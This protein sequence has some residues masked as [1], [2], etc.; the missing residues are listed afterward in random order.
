MLNRIMIVEDEYV[1][2]LDLKNLLEDL[3]HQV[4]AMVARGEDVVAQA[5]AMQPDMVLMDIRLAGA[6]TGT[7][8]A[9]Q[10]KAVMNVPVIFLSAY[11]DDSVL[12]EA[13]KSFPHG[14]LVKPFERRELAAT[15][16]MAAVRHRSE[17]NYQI[18]ERRLRMAIEAAQLSYFELNC[19]TDQLQFLG[20]HHEWLDE[21]SVNGTESLLS[22]VSQPQ[23]GQLLTQLERHNIINAVYEGGAQ[24]LGGFVEIHAEKLLLGLHP[25]WIGIVADVSERHLNEIQLRQAKAVFDTTNEA[26]LILDVTGEVVAANPAFSRVTGYSLQQIAKQSPRDFLYDTTA[27]LTPPQLHELSANHWSGEVCC[28]KHDG[29]SFPAWLHICK[30]RAP[31][32]KKPIDHY[33]LMFSDISALRRAEEHLIS[34]VHHD[35]LTGLGNR[36]KLEKVLHTEIMRA[37]RYNTSFGVLYLDLDGFKLVNDT[38][39]HHIGDRLLQHIANRIGQNIRLGDTPVRVGGDEFVIVVPDV[40]S[41]SD[42][43]MIA[44]KLLHIISADIDLDDNQVSI[45]SSIGIAMYPTD[46]ESADELLKCADLAMFNAKDEGRNRYAFFNQILAEKAHMRVRLERD[47]RVSLQQD[48]PLIQL[49]YQPIYDTKTLQ[50]C[51]V[52]ALLRWVHPELGFVAPDRFVKVA[53]QSNLICELGELVFRR[54]IADLPRMFQFLAE[55]TY[56]A[57]NLSAKQFDDPMLLDRLKHY[58]APK[59]LWPNIQ[60]EVT[61][62]AFLQSHKLEPTL[63]AIQLTGATVALDDFGTGYSSLSRLKELP[64]NCLKI[65]RSFVVSISNNTKSLEIVRAVCTLGKALDLVLVAEGVETR[66]Q[67]EI[68]ATMGCDRIQGYLFAKPMPVEQMIEH[69]IAKPPYM[70]PSTTS[71]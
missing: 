14:Y 47:L 63:Q 30:V 69:I 7:E 46:A 32:P 16:R 39:G 62:T 13:E 42:C 2:S 49:Y 52:E 36:R 27:T 64:L 44:D 34:L 17:L 25:S 70:P 57:V 56:I 51:G 29:L 8:A 37:K 50:L 59:N 3:G 38:L 20:Y 26:I 22:I 45:S 41:P 55:S 28:V 54:L 43:F 40:Q 4:V 68:L 65:D 33:V 18:S 19:E 9:Q 5:S 21:K 48:S 15:I 67:F 12:A 71:S 11:S 24:L 35:H 23:Q 1:V 61:E 6:V 60:F 31:L 58:F 53:E 10:L 66:E